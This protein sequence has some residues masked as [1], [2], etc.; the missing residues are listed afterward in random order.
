MG[1]WNRTSEHPS[2]HRY[3]L[4][5]CFCQTQRNAMPLSFRGEQMRSSFLLNRLVGLLA[6]LFLSEMQGFWPTAL[7]SFALCRVTMAN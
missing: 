3:D 6:R 1:H 7:I 5:T 2:V 4:L